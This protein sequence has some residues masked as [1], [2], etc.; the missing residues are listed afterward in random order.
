VGA[1][2]GAAH[3]RDQLLSRPRSATT[4]EKTA[5]PQLSQIA[6]IPADLEPLRAFLRAL[7]E[8]YE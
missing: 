7:N 5:D 8:D 4:H 1:R 6:L 2:R 3:L